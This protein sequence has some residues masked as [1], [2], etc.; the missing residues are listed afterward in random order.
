[1][2]K[3][4]K[5]TK[6]HVNFLRFIYLGIPQAEAFIEAGFRAKSYKS[7]SSGSSTLLEKL[8]RLPEGKELFKTFNPLDDVAQDIATL[9]KN[10]DPRI[11]LDA[12]KE[13]AK[14]HGLVKD[15]IPQSFGFQVNIIGRLPD[16]A[17]PA[18]VGPAQEPQSLLVKT[19]PPQIGAPKKPVG[20]SK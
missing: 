6:K 20:L 14:I 15:E 12:N 11:S 2:T 17:G 9:R 1:M 4:F 19:P 10:K 8:R 16:E 13:A 3:A 18:Q 7:A 5:L